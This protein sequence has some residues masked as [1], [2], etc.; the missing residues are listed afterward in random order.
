MRAR[1]DGDFRGESTSVTIES[2][3][4]KGK[5]HGCARRETVLYLE[6]HRGG[7]S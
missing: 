1:G 7:S 4:T 6:S 5:Q 2:T 3:E